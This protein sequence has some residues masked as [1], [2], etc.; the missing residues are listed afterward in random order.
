MIMEQF[1]NGKWASAKRAR[2]NLWL[3]WLSTISR[4]SSRG[5]S[6]TFESGEKNWKGY[7]TQHS[8]SQ[9]SRQVVKWTEKDMIHSIPEAKFLDK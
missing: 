1:T 5:S 7:D 8:V 3:F 6:L 4:L 2:T 9:V